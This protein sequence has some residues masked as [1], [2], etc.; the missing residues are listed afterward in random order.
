MIRMIETITMDM[1]ISLLK[2]RVFSLQYCSPDYGSD[3]DNGNTAHWAEPLPSRDQC[4]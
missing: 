3:Q 4:N 2:Y 1:A